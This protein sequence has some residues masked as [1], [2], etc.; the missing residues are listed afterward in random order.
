[1]QRTV[2]VHINGQSFF[3]DE[4]AHVRLDSYLKK[5]Q[6]RYGQTEGGAEIIA[7]IEGR[8][9]ELFLQKTNP[10]IGVVTR[11]MVEDSILV[12]G[13]PEQFD[14]GQPIGNN[15]PDAGSTLQPKAPKR[16]YRDPDNRVLGG[17][18]AGFSAYFGV[19]VTL[20]RILMVLVTLLSGFTVAFV[21]LLLWVILPEA[22]LPSQKL[23]M[24]GENINVENIEKAVKQE[25]EAVKESFSKMEQSEAFQ[26]SKRYFDRLNQRDRTVLIVIGVVIAAMAIGRLFQLPLFPLL[27]ITMGNW[28][29]PLF[30]FGFIFPIIVVMLGVGLVYRPLLKPVLWVVAILVLL[31]LA[32]G[33]LW[34]FYN[35]VHHIVF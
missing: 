24:R 19:D 21:Y 9:A 18:C 26:N 8:L 7:D 34:P 35:M 14:D 10:S 5:L 31:G 33:L 32:G 13:E 29:W 20:V 11:Q 28:H 2:N 30:P 22:V 12:M 6:H 17:V 3:M 27:S 25:F 4:D 1:M 23:E 15:G 16:L